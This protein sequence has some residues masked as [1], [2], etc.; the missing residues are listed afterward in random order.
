MSLK[1]NRRN[2][3][4]NTAKLAGGVTALAAFNACSTLDEYIFEDSFYLKD[5]TVIVGGG[6]AGMYL[7]YKLRQNKMSYRIF[8]ASSRL[9]GRIRSD[10]GIDCGAS[11]FTNADETLK[12]LIKEY[13]IAFTAL[14][15]KNF[16]VNDG[17]QSVVENLREHISGLIT[18]RSVR[19]RWKL[20]SVQ[21][22]NNMYEVVFEGPGGRRTYV[23]KKLVLAMPPP[24]WAKVKGLYDLPE[25]QPLK[26]WADALT[27]Q[28]TVKA[29]VTSQQGLATASLGRGI[30]FYSDDNFEVRQIVKNTKT[31][32]TWVEVDFTVK[33]PQVSLEIE[34]INDFLKKRMGLN[35]S[36]AKMGTDN[37]FDWG[38]VSFIQGSKFL[39]AAALPE[40]RSS[41]LQVVG[42][43]SRLENNGTIEGAMLSAVRAADYLL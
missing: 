17:M 34:K 16:Y 1:S 5:Q 28:N 11:V 9:G 21:K 32:G 3:I 37:Y 36:A 13:N 42:D 33:V 10:R 31:N 22:I 12:S 15:R 7:A 41:S 14:D 43:F 39:S 24:Q 38:K 4:L 40:I 25:M 19:L 20:I 29:I 2:F 27:V 23:S 8:E 30:S 18:Y 35:F 26:A 6:I